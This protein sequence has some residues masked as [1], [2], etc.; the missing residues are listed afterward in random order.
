M[1][2]RQAKDVIKAIK[3]RLVSKSPTGQ[4]Y[5]VT[6]GIA[7]HPFFKGKITV[8]YTTFQLIPYYNTNF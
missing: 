4:L 6:V 3:R 2:C 7:G 1:W 5:A 8:N